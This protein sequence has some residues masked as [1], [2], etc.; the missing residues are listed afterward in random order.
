MLWPK[1]TLQTRFS[2]DQVPNFSV[3]FSLTG[4]QGVSE[5]EALLLVRRFLLD[6]SLASEHLLK[7]P[8]GFVAL[9]SISTSGGE[10]STAAKQPALL[11]F[12]L[13]TQEKFTGPLRFIPHFYLTH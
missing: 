5:K 11:D 7:G 8:S 1:T 13:T 12:S 10:L 3:Y 6:D 9:S 2:Q 4:L